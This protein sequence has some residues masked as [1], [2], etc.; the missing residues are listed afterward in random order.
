M[1]RPTIQT[2]FNRAWNWYIRDQQPRAVGLKGPYTRCQYFTKD[3]TR[4]A[5]GIQLRPETAKQLEETFS[6]G[7]SILQLTTCIDNNIFSAPL[8]RTV[9]KELGFTGLHLTNTLHD[10]I[11]CSK[12]NLLRLN[13]LDELQ[14]TH[15]AYS[16]FEFSEFK[17]KMI[18]LA[19]DYKLKLPTK[20][21][22]AKPVMN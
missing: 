6:Y 10:I 9:F 20:N 2:M 11:Y 21:N 17:S 14:R 18:L 4:C 8:V 7:I 16:S 1:S 13:F 3:C 12:E 19:D 5:I 15:D 22:R